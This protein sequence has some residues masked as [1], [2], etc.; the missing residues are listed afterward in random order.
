MFC[1]VCGKPLNDDAQFCSYCG[2]KVV[3]PESE[4]KTPLP[5]ETKE[6]TTDEQLIQMAQQM[7]TPH[8][9]DKT[10]PLWKR[11]GKKLL[12][13]ISAA[14]CFL[15][16]VTAGTIGK[17]AAHDPNTSRTMAYVL[18]GAMA[19]LVAGILCCIL[20]SNFEKLSHKKAWMAAS[21]VICIAAGVIGGYVFAAGAGVI[22]ALLL[23]GCSR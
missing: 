21:V 19:G 11:I 22:F 12:S 13:W 16:I 7:M 2:A 8:E 10:L 17:M 5:A 9:V 18:P 14:V 15:V 20:A 3:I 6:Q 1:H 4:G 23:F